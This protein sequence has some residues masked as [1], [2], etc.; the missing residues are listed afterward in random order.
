MSNRH[1]ERPDQAEAHAEAQSMVSRYAKRHQHADR[2][3]LQRHE[4]QH[5]VNERQAALQSLLQAEGWQPLSQRRVLDVGCGD[6]SNLLALIDAG[7]A[8]Q[9]AQGIDLLPDRI[10]AARALL[11]ASVVLRAGDATSMDVP[12]Q[13]IDL[14]LQYTVFSS[15][16]LDA[17]REALAQ[18]MW[19]WL[20]PGGAVISYDFCV[21]SPGNHEVRALT[22]AQLAALFPQGVVKHVRRVTLAQPLA[23]VLA[24]VHPQ[25]HDAVHAVPL[26]RTHRMVWLHKP[27]A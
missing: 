11:P 19:R 1:T 24:R 21:P 4:V 16:L 6:G 15:L 7:L 23:R 14:C 17:S 5:L 18:A 26:L 10:A 9:H 2:Y 20:K 13:S 22:V 25:L 8:P 27:L 3:S 12:A